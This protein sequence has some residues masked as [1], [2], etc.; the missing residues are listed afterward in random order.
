NSNILH[1]KDIV[2]CELAD[3]TGAWLATMQ[4][5]L[6]HVLQ[7][8]LNA[9][10]NTVGGSKHKGQRTS[11]SSDYT[12]R[13]RS[14]HKFSLHVRVPNELADLG[15]CCGVN[16]GAVNEELLRRARRGHDGLSKQL[17]K[18]PLHMMWLRKHGDYGI[19]FHKH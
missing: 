14:I 4:D 9:R 18:D 12:T 3:D 5:P 8:R 2:I 11:L 15:G 17:A 19:L 1:G 7:Y 6:S 13:N 10:H 16:G